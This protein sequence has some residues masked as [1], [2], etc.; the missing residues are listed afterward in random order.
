MNNVLNISK[1]LFDTFAKKSYSSCFNP[2]KC[3]LN[4]DSF[5]HLSLH[6]SFQVSIPQFINEQAL[7]H[8]DL[9][10]VLILIRCRLS[11]FMLTFN[12]LQSPLNRVLF[13]FNRFVQILHSSFLIFQF[14]A[15]VLHYRMNQ[16][17]LNHLPSSAH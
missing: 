14:L 4:I 3:I 6:F 9:T 8:F 1:A 2:L 17:T 13:I 5:S 10:R 11:N 15:N 16:L 12:S 7:S